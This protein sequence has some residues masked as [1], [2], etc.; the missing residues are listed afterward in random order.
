MSSK[1]M[2]QCWAHAQSAFE[3]SGKASSELRNSISEIKNKKN[4]FQQFLDEKYEVKVFHCSQCQFSLDG[5]RGTNLWPMYL[6]T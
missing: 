5:L 1:V 2:V 6:T 3:C 4:L